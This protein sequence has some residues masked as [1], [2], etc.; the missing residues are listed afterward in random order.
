MDMLK[1]KISK[2]KLKENYKKSIISL[3]LKLKLIKILNFK[4]IHWQNTN[5]LQKL[6]NHSVQHKDIIKKFLIKIIH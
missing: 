6:L 5:H 3:K 1:I 2:L 4:I